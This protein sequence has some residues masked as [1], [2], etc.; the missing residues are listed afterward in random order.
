[1]PSHTPCLLDIA[2]GCDLSGS[3]SSIGNNMWAAVNDFVR[4]FVTGLDAQMNGS[5]AGIPGSSNVQ[6]GTYVWGDYNLQPSTNLPWVGQVVRNMTDNSHIL[7]LDASNPALNQILGVNVGTSG[8]D[9]DAAVSMGMT[10][11]NNFGALGNRSSQPNY[12][13]IM[14]IVTDAESLYACTGLPT[15]PQIGLQT[16]MANDVW[17]VGSNAGSPELDVEVY[18]FTV[19]PGAQ[20]PPAYPGNINCLV[21]ASAQATNVAHGTGAVLGTL[22]TTLAN[23]LCLGLPPTYDCNNTGQTISLTSGITVQPWDC[24]DPGTGLGQYMSATQCAAN[25]NAPLDTY[26]CSGPPNW[27]CYI[28]S[29]GVGQFTGLTAQ[30][31]CQ[32]VCIPPIIPPSWNCHIPFGATIGTCTDPGT[33]LGQY[34]AA[35]NYPNPYQ[36]CV[37]ACKDLP[38]I[39]P[40][41]GEDVSWN[42]TWKKVWGIWN[43]SCSSVYGTGGQYTGPTGHQDCLDACQ[44]HPFIPPETGL[45][46]DDPCELCC[47]ASYQTGPGLPWIC[48]PGTQV[49]SAANLNPCDCAELGPNMIDCTEDV[50]PPVYGYN[51]NNMGACIGPIV[52]GTYTGANAA[53]NLNPATPGINYPNSLAGALAYCEDSC[54]PVLGTLCPRIRSCPCGWIHSLSTTIAGGIDCTDPT[55]VSTMLAIEKC[56]EFPMPNYTP[57]VG[58]A[59]LNSGFYGS[60]TWNRAVVVDI[61][62]TIITTTTQETRST[63]N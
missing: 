48:I 35:N 2:I 17:Y 37:D 14:I 20:P 42:C 6:V 50:G 45:T 5:I 30:A 31:D 56:M 54:L 24:Y 36:D 59:W 62:G 38:Y 27:N 34:S 15:L 53:L 18:A 33:G 43:G 58:D 47:C 23:T 21:P 1:V 16:N 4:E 49:M 44:E 25:C 57:A 19:H 12:R 41:T 32:A 60:I 51:C 40:E 3:M 7:H 28:P 55:G 29:I 8:D 11:L 46:G 39:P 22:G 26:D 52:N 10:M 9:Y 61:T 13:R 63:C